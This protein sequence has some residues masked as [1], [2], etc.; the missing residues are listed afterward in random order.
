[1]QRTISRREVEGNGRAD[2]ARTW[3]PLAVILLLASVLLFAHLG[4][5]YLWED[6]GDTAVLARTI[7]RHGLPLAWD[8]VTFSDSDYGQRLK[9]GFVMVSHPWL[10]YYAAAASF[11]LFGE[12]PL[13]ARLPFALA[14]LVVIGL[15]YAMAIRLLRNR[16]AAV[17]AAL[18][19]MV[20]VQFLLYSRQARNYSLHALLTC[21]L[22]WQ[23][24]RLRSRRSAVAFAAIG[25][26]LFH[27][28][29]IGLAAVASLALLTLHRSQAPARRWCLPA[30][31]VVFAYAAPWVL[32]SRDGHAT[33]TDGAASASS[34]I[35]RLLQFAAEYGS[36]TP[37]VGAV[38]LLIVLWRRHVRFSAEERNLGWSVLSVVVGEAVVMAAT[39]ST[40]DMWILGLHHTPALIPLTILLAALF[41]TKVSGSSRVVL[42]SLVLLFGV[43]RVAHLV[44]W[45]AWASAAMPSDASAEEI[46]LHVPE[47]TADRL[48][49]TTQVQYV[50]S[51]SSPNPGVIQRVSEFLRANGSPG[52]I[53][54]TNYEWNA[55]YFHTG[56]PQGAKVSPSFPIYSV[57]RANNLP[58]YVFGADG[59]RWIVWRRAW[60]AYFPEQDCERLLRRLT[61][62]GVTTELVASF[63]ETL[64]ENRENVH[65]RRYPDNTYVFPWYPPLPDVQVYRIDWESD[66][67]ARHQRAD[68][69]WSTEDYAAAI[70]DYQAYLAERP[71]DALAWTRLG[72]SFIATGLLSDAVEAFRASVK[73]APRDPA[74][75]RNL[76]LALLDSGHIDEATV[77][78]NRAIALSP[79]DREM[80]DALATALAG[81]GAS[82]SLSR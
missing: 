75:Q 64:F 16:G 49:R 43:T 47:T 15:V 6:E 70:N 17:I 7:V 22:V 26:L 9:F 8:G 78:A 50:R 52:D 69:L 53:V 54:I 34:F 35:V 55:L 37:V 66:V 77:H 41:I 13:A 71:G 25:I 21:L 36:V 57:A 81:R 79:D 56:M 33:S 11:A 3:W 27:T 42:V 80:R 38:A 2:G 19:L 29:P 30:V 45:V 20:S 32:L 5:D 10:Q 12:S 28:H 46:H 58:N 68:A 67:E 39:H 60:P 62:A 24:Q 82:S 40:A 4:R 51:L 31:A 63:A 59:V 14:G 61:A 18:L 74:A 23:F 73:L 48:L 44:P 72:I 1:M 76:A 65:F